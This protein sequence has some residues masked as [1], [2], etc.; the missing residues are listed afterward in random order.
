MKSGRGL[1]HSITWR[2]CRGT[3]DPRVSVVECGSPLPLFERSAVHDRNA[4]TQRGGFWS[5]LLVVC[6]AL[7]SRWSAVGQMPVYGDYYAHDPSRLI[8]QGNTYYLY[9]T[10]QGIMSKYST[11]L[12]NWTYGGQVFSAGPP[13]WTSNAVPGFTGF[14]WAPDIVLLNGVYYLYYAV[15]GFGVQISAIGLATTTNLASGNWVDQGSV[16]QSTTGDP[17]NC[18]DPCP[19]VDTNGTMWLT[20][21][22]YWNGIYLTQLDPATGKRLSPS[23]TTTRLAFNSSIEASFLYQRG[24]YYYLFVNFGSCCSGIDSTYNIRVGRSTSITGPYLDRKGASMLSSGGSTFL[25]STARFVGPGHAGIMNDNGTNWFTYHYYDGNNGGTAS[26]GLAPLTW[27]ADGW[28]QVTNDWSAFY[29]LQVDAREHLGLYNGALSNSAAIVSEPGRGNVLSLNGASQFAL[30]PDPVANASSFAAWVKWNSGADWQRIF[31]FGSNT[32]RYFFLT[33]RAANGR[34]RF[35]ITTAGNGAEQVFDAPTALATGSWQHVAVTLDGARGVM[36]LNGAPLAT[37]NSLTI[38]PWQVLARSNYLGK[39][40]FSMDPS[41]NGL[42]DSFR[43]FSRALSPAEIRDMA[44]AHPALAHRYSFTSNAWDSIGMAHGFL[45]GSASV[46]NNALRLTGTAGDYVNLPGG[47]LSGSS[48]AT[49]EAWATFGANGNWARL[50]D[51]G[52]ISGNNGQNYLFFSPHTGTGTHRTEIS[53]GTLANLDIPGTL[54]NRTVHITCIEDPANGYSAIY[55]NGVLERA[56]TNS[57]P[58]L[59]GVSSA[60]SFVGRSLF[61]A[62]A[63]L[64][65]TI[66]ELRIYDGRLTPQEIAFDYQNSPDAL[67]LRVNLA[68]SQSGSALT[69]SWPSYAVGFVLESSPVLGSSSA[70]SPI[71]IAPVLSADAWSVT[72][73]SAPQTAFYRLR[74]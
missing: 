62:D 28:P 50:L 43:V 31:D 45:M 22:S 57:L 21:G 5:A 60:W 69:L 33:P 37:N 9:R 13:A 20:F 56:A 40:Q 2:K 26:L 51:F 27:S 68:V 46:T 18:I 42:L 67:A 39:S 35:A 23:S 72:L 73:T 32:T 64:N 34:M 71:A 4:R 15:S 38:R 49:I 65:A 10:S 19:L 58:A 54:D 29:P 25:E 48:A 12:R 66:D 3:H 44:W 30:L 41:F 1:P 61:S 55:T 63:W 24:G 11:D 53:S 6:L 70:W 14:F 36:Y 52:N 59:S 17:Y 74:R 8:K 47:L 16:I 7:L